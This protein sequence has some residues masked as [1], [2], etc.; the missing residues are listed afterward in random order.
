MVSVV[1]SQARWVTI[2]LSA[3]VVGGIGVTGG[4]GNNKNAPSSSDKNGG[5]GGL[6]GGGGGLEGLPVSRW[7]T[8]TGA[9]ASQGDLY[10]FYSDLSVG[11]NS[12]FS[13]YFEANTLMT[14]EV[15]GVAF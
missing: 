6:R 13:V 2:D 7:V 15:S 10:V 5:G 1:Y 11:P 9:D 12:T 14:F 3:F 8:N 4:S